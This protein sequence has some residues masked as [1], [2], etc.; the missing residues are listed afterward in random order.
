MKKAVL[1]IVPLLL[2]SFVLAG[3][4]GPQGPK[5]DGPIGPPTIA[6]ADILA[7]Y[8]IEVTWSDVSEATKYSVEAHV[9][10]IAVDAAATEQP[11]DIKICVSA[12]EAKAVLNI[13][14][15]VDDDLADLGP[16]AA[17][18]L[19]VEIRVKAM[20]PGKKAGPQNHPWSE[21]VAITYEWPGEVE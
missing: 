15:A 9:T 1:V 10:G 13:L 8:T 12:T 17:V 7:D 6:T 14:Q 5:G 18:E 11:I 4:K 19:K 16:A 3:P 21:P 20:N 2:V